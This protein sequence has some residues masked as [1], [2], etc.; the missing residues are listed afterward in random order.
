MKNYK[1]GIR[2][3]FGLGNFGDDALMVVLYE[4]LARH[5]D[6][7]NMCILA[8]NAGYIDRFLENP[9]CVD[10]KEIIN[11]DVVVDHLIYGGGTQFYDFPTKSLKFR[12]ENI[13][14]D[15]LK[16]IINKFQ[17]KLSSIFRIKR[18]DNKFRI[19]DLVDEYSL[20]AVGF[21]PFSNMEGVSAIQ[22]RSLLSGARTVSVRD[23]FSKH[24]C[25]SIDV[26]STKVPDLCFGSSS[27]LLNDFSRTNNKSLEK[28]CVVVRD[29]NHDQSGK[30]HERALIDAAGI[31]KDEGFDVEIFLF[32]KTDQRCKIY[33]EQLGYKVHEWDPYTQTIDSFSNKLKDFDLIITSRYHGAI[34]SV[35][36]GIPFIAVEVEPKLLLLEEE[37]IGSCDVWRKPFRQEDLISHVMNIKSNFEEFLSATNSHRNEKIRE[38]LLCMEAFVDKVVKT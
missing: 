29:W 9:V 1:Y 16:S 10:P 37:F 38:S 7:G 14:T 17:V 5:V 22:S 15:S 34:Y 19:V 2:G 23:R 18:V 24:F 26:E 21:G 35:I 30:Q 33:S 11:E 13:W 25:E 27:L 3:G 8:S 31:L 36:N 4:E 20:Y 28:I 12:L 32:S 6:R